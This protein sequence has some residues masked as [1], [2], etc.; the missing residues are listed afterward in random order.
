M[1][2]TRTNDYSNEITFRQLYDDDVKL[3]G[4]LGTDI[5]PYNAARMSFDKSDGGRATKE[6]QAGFIKSL[7]KNEHLVPFEHCVLTFDIKAPIFVFRQLFRYRTAAVS[8]KSMRYTEATNVFY[9]PLALQKEEQFYAFSNL[10]MHAL[11]TYKALLREDVP[12]EQARMVLPVNT[13]SHALFT[14][15]L[16]NLF[17]LLDQRLDSHSQEEI[18]FV[19]RRMM[20]VAE[21]AFPMVIG[22]YKQVRG[23]DENDGRDSGSN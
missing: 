16:R 2:V 23:I 15:N 3:C 14:I 21:E 10:V 7:I 19:A 22:C 4:A 13:F 12:K 18:R 5:T 1:S 9:I 11:D 6:K 8:E 20:A 17:H